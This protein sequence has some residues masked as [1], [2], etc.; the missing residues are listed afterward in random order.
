MSE[1]A[2]PGLR[3]TRIEFSPRATRDLKRLDPQLR[4]QAQEAFH[5][6]MKHPRPTRIRFKKF[7]YGETYTM[8]ITSDGS[9]KA[10]LDLAGDTA[11]VRRVG[12]H[13]AI[14]ANP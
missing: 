8:H 6:L 3:I 13:Q 7:S 12:T 5:D 4:R 11:Y 2:N 10:S 1:Q 9:H 14:D